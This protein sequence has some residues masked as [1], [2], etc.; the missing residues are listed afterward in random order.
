MYAMQTPVERC[1][2]SKRMC[3]ELWPLIACQAPQLPRFALVAS[4]AALAH[5]HHSSITKLIEIGNY[6]SAA[7]LIRPLVETAVTGAWALYCAPTE[8]IEG[9]FRNTHKMPKPNSMLSAIAKRPELKDKLGLKELMD[10]QGAALH[11]YTHGDMDQL[12]RRFSTHGY[13]FSKRENTGSLYIAD[14]MLLLA[15]TIFS[16]TTRERNLE[17]FLKHHA[18]AVIEELR[19]DGLDVSAWKGWQPLPDPAIPL[20]SIPKKQ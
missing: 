15:T 7:A 6:G 18:D 4:T 2:Q 14:L 16:V 13:T 17:K 11:R 12:R 1:T 9:L 5:E 19:N 3:A 20:G 8:V 10:G